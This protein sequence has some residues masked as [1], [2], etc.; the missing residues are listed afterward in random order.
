VWK[1][2]KKNKLP[3]IPV[4]KYKKIGK[5]YPCNRSWRPI[6]LWDVEAPIFSRQSAHRWR[7]GRQPHTPAALYL[8]GRFLVLISVRGRLRLEGL[9]QLKNSMTSLSYE[10]ATFRLVA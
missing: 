7:W 2:A 3:C 6:G 9:C 4:Y 8:P 10:P 1:L 5:T